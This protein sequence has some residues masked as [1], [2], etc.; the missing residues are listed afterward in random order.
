MSYRIYQDLCVNVLLRMG[1][2]RSVDGSV[3]T[4]TPVVTGYLKAIPALLY[5]ALSLLST[6]GKYIVKSL[7]WKKEEEGLERLA[8]KTAA[9]DFFSLAER[10]IY[11]DD[12]PTT[13]YR[14]EG[15]D[16]FTARRAGN[17]RIYYNSYPQSLSGLTSTTALELD[18][19]VYA[20]LPLYIEGKLRQIN[21]EDYAISILNEFEQR[22]AELA[23]FAK[24]DVGC[25]VEVEEYQKAVGDFS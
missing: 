2:D 10:Q 14:L 20:V 24:K 3:I 16:I 19:E 11:L 22:R 21:E 1:E 6:A 12:E 15:N 13:L 17:W 18:P 25:A 5:D 9:S 4:Q 8:L 7:E 23:A